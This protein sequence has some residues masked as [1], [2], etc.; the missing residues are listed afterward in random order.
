M[1]AE[2]IPLNIHSST[3]DADLHCIVHKNQMKKGAFLRGAVR[4]IPV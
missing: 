2:T 3:M 1:K 4:V